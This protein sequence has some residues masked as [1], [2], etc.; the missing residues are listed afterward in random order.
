MGGKRS[1]E[2]GGVW[3][4][5]GGME[6]GRQNFCNFAAGQ[7]TPK[8]LGTDQRE[9]ALFHGSQLTEDEPWVSLCTAGERGWERNAP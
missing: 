9:A 6:K 7:L 3:A 4:E 5:S 2:L 1:E 8:L